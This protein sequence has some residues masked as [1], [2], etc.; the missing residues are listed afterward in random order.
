VD[1]TQRSV[2]IEAIKL[3]PWNWSAWVDLAAVLK[4]AEMM[5]QVDNQLPQH[6]FKPFWRAHSYLELQQNQNAH[7]IYLE[8]LEIFPTSTFIKCQI[9]LARYNLQGK[10]RS[11]NFAS[12][13]RN[14]RFNVLV[15]L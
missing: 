14:L 3:Y 9:A 13:R 7:E 4:D 2:L 5:H 6:F 15:L 8:L 12:G 10:L 1:A 11:L